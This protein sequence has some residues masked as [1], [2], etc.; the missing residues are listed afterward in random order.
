MSKKYAAIDFGHLDCDSGAVIVVN[1]KQIKEVD[2]NFVI[3]TKT[4]E[5]L[6]RHGVAVLKTKG[7][8][9]NRTNLANK[10]KVDILVSVHNNAGGGDGFG[11]YI[12][13]TGGQAEKLAKKI[14]HQ[15]INVDKLNNPHGNPLKAPS[16]LHVLR[17]TSM[18]AVLVECAF[19]DSKDFAAI[20]TTAELEQFG[21]SIAKG[22]LSYFGITYKEK[23]VV[24]QKDGFYRVVTGS[25]QDKKLAEKRMRELEKVGFE[26][27]LDYYKK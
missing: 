23:P 3:A 10:N 2:L 19:I 26:S 27:F 6:E 5:V 9:S 21:I 18:P 8:L 22:I 1:G 14:N 20:D 25:F 16:N 13:G 24:A 15:V 11:T 4:V 7:S 17:E 12:Y